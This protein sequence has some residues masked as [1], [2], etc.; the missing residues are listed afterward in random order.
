MRIFCLLSS[1]RLHN[2]I[3]LKSN[4]VDSDFDDGF[5]GFFG[6]EGLVGFEG[7]NGFEGLCGALGLR[8]LRV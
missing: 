3:N 7:N 1:P 8:G 2:N 6:F 5:E 4:F